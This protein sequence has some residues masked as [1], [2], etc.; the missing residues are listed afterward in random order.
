VNAK[1]EAPSPQWVAASSVTF[2]RKI[3]D[4]YGFWLPLAAALVGFKR[5]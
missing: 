2:V 4:M 1:I 5:Y 3:V